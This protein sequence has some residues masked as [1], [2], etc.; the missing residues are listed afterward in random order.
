MLRV[1]AQIQ[2][3]LREFDFSFSRSSGAGG[4]NVNKVNTKV[5]LR[6]DLDASPS[7]SEAVKARFR[8]RFGRRLTTAGVLVVQSQRFRDQGRNVADC[9]E[10]LR[11]MLLEVA[12]APKARRATKPGRGARERRLRDKRKTGERKQRRARVTGDD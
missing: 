8:A 5:T 10:K 2:I 3:P 9:L 1:N 6:W 12:T 4:Q 11:Q 7:L